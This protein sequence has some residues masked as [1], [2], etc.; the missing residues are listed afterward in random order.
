M[1]VTIQNNKNPTQELNGRYY[2]TFTPR[3]PQELIKIHHMG[4]IG[5][6]ELK[7]IQ[8]EKGNT[9]TA[10]V[11]PK[12]TQMATSGILNDLRSLNL[13][14]T[15][16]DSDL[17]G[18]I[19]ANNKGMLTEF[20]DSNIKSAIATS[21]NNIMQQIN[22]TLN[23]DYSSFNQRLDALRSTVKNEAVSSTVTQL[24]DTYDRK[25]ATANEN[26]VSRVNQSINNVTT[27]VQELERG[28]V[29]RS[30]ISVTSDGLSFGSSKVIDGQTLSS[31]LNVTPNMMTAITKQMRVT[32]DM[33]VNG[34]ITS[35][36]IQANSITAGHLASGSISA[37]KLDVDDAFLNTLV[38]QDSFFE[39]MKAK[40]AF[41]SAVQAIDIKATQLSAEFL[42]AYKGHI[43]GFQIGSISFINAFG[44]KEYYTGKFI[45]GKNEFSVGMSNGDGTSPERVA[46][47][48][49]WGKKWNEIPENG[50]YINHDGHMYAKGGTDFQG[51]VDFKEQ[52]KA[53]FYGTAYFGSGATFHGSTTFNDKITVN[54]QAEFPQGLVASGRIGASG[55]IYTGHEDVYGEGSHPNP[56]VATNAVVW[57]NQIGSGSVKYWL[58]Q[59]SDSRLK[60]NVKKTSVKG[61]KV[62]NQLELV[63]FDWRESN[64]NESIGL[65][66]Q[67]VEKIVPQAVLTEEKRDFKHIDYK[68]F[69]P[70][71]IKAI[72]ELSTKVEE[73]ERKLQ[74]E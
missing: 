73:L 53:N 44:D 5:N 50:W 60:K 6:T 61:L 7:N 29:K 55:G 59:P 35:D 14:L 51:Q 34:A 54:R 33:L 1:Q 45:T 40:D 11:E 67:A 17:W 13:M 38:A 62:L 20:F 21:A 46:L 23:G 15:D 49:N 30:D 3:T 68:S 25:I 22:S 37:S 42:S 19:K 41:I 69:V 43:G 9:P 65:I 24:A 18:R 27:S 47:W 66:A 31:I 71:L 39:K 72:Q 56:D 48:V 2:Q 8:L 36:K 63:T 52:S 74:H 64:K 58:S 28:V 57:W 12:I 4:C 16:V 10:F 70:Y 26:V 32:G